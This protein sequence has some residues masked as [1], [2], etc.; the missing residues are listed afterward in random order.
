MSRSKTLAYGAIAIVLLIFVLFIFPYLIQYNLI[1]SDLGTNLISEFIGMLVTL[2]LFV[3]F[4][5][6]REKMEWKRVE[7]KVYDRI[8]KKMIQL[9]ST[10]MNYCMHPQRAISSESDR[11]QYEKSKKEII[12]KIWNNPECLS[13]DSI[14]RIYFKGPEGPER[15]LLPYKDFLS[16][17]EI[18][19]LDHLDTN[20]QECLINLQDYLENFSNN[21]IEYRYADFKH[22][23][24][25]RVKV[26]KTIGKIILEIKKLSENGITVS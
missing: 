13:L 12:E 11:Q 3:I 21:L 20:I 23:V 18:K 15:A 2:V 24:E 4:L 14:T 8:G 26:E 7:K 22:E 19:Y 16:L 5:D 9:L 6:V 1:A 25:A 10:L 17:I